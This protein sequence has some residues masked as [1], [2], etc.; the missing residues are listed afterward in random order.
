MHDYDIASTD[1]VLWEFAA[2]ERILDA[3]ESVIGPSIQVHHS[4]MAW[5]PA[6]RKP[7][8]FP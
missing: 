1:P 3:V 5:T 8:P 2:H 7:E 4:K 6:S